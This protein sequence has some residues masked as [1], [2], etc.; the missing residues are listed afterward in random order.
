M[1][2]ICWSADNIWGKILTIYSPFECPDKTFKMKQYLI[3]ILK[4]KVL[5][6]VFV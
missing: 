5:E 1:Y 3:N 4:K 2:N 6:K